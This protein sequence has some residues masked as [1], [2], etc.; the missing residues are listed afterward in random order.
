[1]HDVF[2]RSKEPTGRTYSAS[3]EDLAKR[4]CRDK[5]ERVAAESTAR[6]DACAKAAATY[7]LPAPLLEQVVAAERCA[8]GSSDYGAKALYPRARA[9][10]AVKAS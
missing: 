2:E 4:N 9:P 8:R 7:G 1:M 3:R 5:E 6:H 10:V